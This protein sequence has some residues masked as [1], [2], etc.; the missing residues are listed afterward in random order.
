MR[1][2]EECLRHLGSSG[3]GGCFG[4]TR[5]VSPCWMRQGR[6][7]TKQLLGAGWNA[8]LGVFFKDGDEDRIQESHE[9]QAGGNSGSAARRD[10]GCCAVWSKQAIVAVRHVSEAWPVRLESHTCSG[11]LEV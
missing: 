10:K 5:N 6:E 3:T 7:R 8:G 4:R 1:A 9:G 11:R 2:E